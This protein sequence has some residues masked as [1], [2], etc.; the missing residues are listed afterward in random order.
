MLRSKIDV[1]VRLEKLVKIKNLFFLKDN[2]QTELSVV[3]SMIEA[4]LE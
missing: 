2:K 1:R 4:L 3:R